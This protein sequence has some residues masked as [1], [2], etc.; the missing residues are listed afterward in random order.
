M[1]FP[2]LPTPD[3]ASVLQTLAG[4]AQAQPD[5]GQH[6]VPYSSNGTSWQPPINSNVQVDYSRPLRVPTPPVK[7][8]DPASIID[9]SSGLRCVMKTI[10]KHDKILQDIRKVSRRIM[11]VGLP[12]S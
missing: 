12:E 2:A 4:L 5:N 8:V 9:W 3:L 7:I 1:S 10:A 11:P 6:N